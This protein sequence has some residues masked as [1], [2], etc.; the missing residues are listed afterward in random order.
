MATVETE[1]AGSLNQL[2]NSINTRL[3]R[4]QF[5]IQ[6]VKKELVAIMQGL[7]VCASQL[8]AEGEAAN[9][10]IDGIE[11]IKQQILGLGRRLNSDGPLTNDDTDQRAREDLAPVRDYIT[12]N[13]KKSSR[14]TPDPDERLLVGDA[15]D[16]NGS[17]SPS[18]K[19]GWFSGWKAPWT[20]SARPN[21]SEDMWNT[22]LPGSRVDAPRDSLNEN[23]DPLFG[24]GDNASLGGWGK[25]K[26]KRTRRKSKTRHR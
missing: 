4:E 3:S 17:S 20:R 18:A 15:P 14:E 2:N 21:P 1:L 24:K 11:R 23:G 12:N 7:E 5:Y 16:V 22:R 26:T 10:D 25:R 13:L 6:S 8:S 9:L 19:K